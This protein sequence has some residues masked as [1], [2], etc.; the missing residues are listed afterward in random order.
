LCLRLARGR[1]ATASVA[2]SVVAARRSAPF[3]AT[4]AVA[5]TLCST[6]AAAL[7]L[8]S[9][10]AAIALI[11]TL[12]SAATSAARFTARRALPLSPFRRADER[13]RRDG[14]DGRGEEVFEA[15][16]LLSSNTVASV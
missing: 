10:T 11:T 14:D 2:I 4:A 9:T 6:T 8:R 16:T 15:H 3:S 12:M 13:R 7:T 1:L 5:L